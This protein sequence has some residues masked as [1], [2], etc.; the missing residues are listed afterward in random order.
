MLAWM[1]REGGEE[2]NKNEEGIGKGRAKRRMGGRREERRGRWGGGREKGG[3]EEGK[4]RE[5][6]ERRIQKTQRN[7]VM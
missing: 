4:R 2:E 1:R 3:R 7:G 5:I 6:K